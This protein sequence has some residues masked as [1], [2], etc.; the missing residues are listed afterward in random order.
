[1]T[2]E[3]PART[4]RALNFNP[5]PSALPQSVLE[6]VRDNLLDFQ[7]TGIGVC[8]HS[9]RAKVIDPIFADAQ[10]DLADLLGI[11]LDDWAVLFLQG[12]A[13]QQ[14]Y[15]IPMNFLQGKTANYLDT[16][17]WSSGAIGEAKFYGTAHVACSSKKDN[18]TY[19]PDSADYA[20]DSVYTH[21][22][23]NNTIFGTQ[24]HSEP[25]A[26]SPLVCD[27]SS[28]ILSRPLAMDKYGMIYAG[29][30]KNLGPA[31]VTIAV[32]KKSFMETGA[33]DLP[34]MAQYRTHA[35]NDS[36]FNTPPVFAIYVVSLVLKWLKGQGGLTAMAKV[37]DRKA[38]LLYG[39]LDS[40]E[41]YRPPVR[42]KDRSKMN[43]VF[44]LPSEELE[45][46]IIKEADAAGL[47]GLK[48]HRS[49]GGL[50]ASIYN[51]M[52]LEGVQQLVDFLKEFERKN[53]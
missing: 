8:E 14:F 7:G 40:T 43:V 16:G 18:Y 2:T 50:R 26:P 34:K 3:T 32:I 37:N 1:M 6:E 22:T 53:G 33:T 42:V 17:T 36:R 25:D 24:F 49:V 44:R 52:P 23:S 39:C 10:N 11:S 27:A 9:H 38:E 21:F 45:A 15:Q 20:A 4:E 28:D 35:A 30:Q 48:G 13:R 5:G 12:G 31:G 46:K 47:K 29:A 51:A 19:I 41:F